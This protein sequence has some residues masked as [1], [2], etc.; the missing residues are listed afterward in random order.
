[1]RKRAANFDDDDEDKRKRWF[2]GFLWGTVVS[3]GASAAA[4]VVLSVFVL[5]PPELPPEPEVSTGP[6]MIN[7]IEVSDAPA[8]TDAGTAESGEADA[9]GATDAPSEAEAPVGPVEL[10]GPALVVNAVPFQ[11]DPETPLVAVVLDDINGVPQLQDALFTLKMPLTVGVVVGDGGDRETASAARKAGLEVLAQLR[12]ERQGGASSGG[13]EYG[14]PEDEATKRTL[15]LIQRLPMA[16]AVSRPLAS[17]APPNATL[18]RGMKDALTPLGFAYVDNGLA[19]GEETLATRTGADAIVGLSYFTI[20]AGA[21]AAAAHAVLDEAAAAAAEQGAAVVF[22]VPSEDL[23]LA[24][25]LWGGAGSVNVAALAP[26]SAA[27]LRQQ[28]E[29]LDQVLGAQPAPPEAANPTP[30]T[31]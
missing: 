18:L 2:R 12:L 8:Y 27:V 26:L 5:P 15:T 10:S 13:L 21:D 30:V 11:A 1:M 22:A 19:P 3:V 20:P 7:G 14:M 29:S 4:I 23:V 25:D 31:K 9:G 16:V 17:I 28:G 6:T 24:L